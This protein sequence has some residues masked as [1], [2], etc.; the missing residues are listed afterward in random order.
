M[1]PYEA[2]LQRRIAKAKVSES[3]YTRRR[4]MLARVKKAVS[5]LDHCRLRRPPVVEGETITLEMW[6]S[7]DDDSSPLLGP[8]PTWLRVQI[9]FGLSQPEI[10]RVI[11]VRVAF[12]H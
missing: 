12:A 6:V 3:Y 4:H 7:V 10:V 2:R 1:N 9:P 5:K 8:T 11:K